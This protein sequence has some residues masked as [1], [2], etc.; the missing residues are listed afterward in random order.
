VSEFAFL[1]L[2]KLLNQRNPISRIETLERNRAVPSARV[3]QLGQI[4]Q[5]TGD[6]VV[7][8]SIVVANRT[9]GL[10]D[11]TINDSGIIVRNQ[12]GQLLF[13]N[14]VSTT[15]QVNI[16]IDSDNYLGL[17]NT[18]NERGFRFD[19]Y[20]ASHTQYVHY[21]RYNGLII[22]GGPS[23]TT[24]GITIPAGNNLILEGGNIYIDGD[25]PI[26]DGWFPTTDTITRTGNHTFT[27]PDDRTNQFRKGAKF[28]YTDAGAGEYGVVASSVYTA[29]DTATT[30]T[31]ITNSDYAMSTDAIADPSLSYI[32]NPADFPDWFNYTPTYSAN[33][34]MTYTTVTTTYAKWRVSGK[35]MFYALQASGTTGGEVNTQLQATPPVTIVDTRAYPGS[36]NVIDGTA[37]AVVG[38]GGANGTTGV[39]FA[40]KF[41]SSNWA[42]GAGR[43]MQSSGFY[44]F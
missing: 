25:N 22:T 28:A 30:V 35:T 29:T 24:S 16:Y 21:I 11:V 42:L 38:T 40:R 13:E 6:M 32:E 20:D 10:A 4:G 27:V 41:D 7:D 1:P 19:A 15:D 26:Q 34:S 31:L 43:V 39:I 3:G 12:E 2:Q 5:S 33:G 37:A 17:Q 8:G 14:T 23:V 44:P 36:C 9:D 18:V